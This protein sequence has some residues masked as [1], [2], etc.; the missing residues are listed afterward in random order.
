MTGAAATEIGGQTTASEYGLMRC[1][2]FATP[3]DIEAHQDT[4]L[5]IV[6]E[7]S[8]A[9]YENDLGKLSRNLERFTECTRYRYGKHAIVFLGDFCQLECIGG[10]VIYN[11][12]Q[13][14]YW[15]QALNSMVELKGTHRYSDCEKMKS[16]MPRV[17]EE[18]LSAEDRKTL[19]SRVID[20]KKIT[21]PDPATT[22]YATYHNKNRCE[23][24]ARVFKNYLEVYHATCT[25]Q[26]IPKTGIVIKANARWA[27]TKVPLSF[28]QRKILFE[29]CSDA[30]CKSG[31]QHCDP[32]L[33]LF[34]NCNVMG[35]TNDD[36]DNGIANGVTAVFKQIHLLDEANLVPIQLYGFWVY[37]VNIQDVKSLEM[38]WQDSRFK[39]RFRVQPKK[40]NFQVRYPVMEFGKMMYLKPTIQF[41]FFPILINHATTGHKL[42]G[43][44]MDELV[45]AEW[46]KVK[47]WAYVVL[48][49]VRTLNGLFLTEEIPED[50]EF[51]PAPKY[52]QMMER[53]RPRILKTPGQVLELLDDEF[54]QLY[55][56]YCT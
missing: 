36:V 19:N 47:N 8:F 33:C 11:H 28:E 13:G 21:M 20:G 44:S 14:I 25:E 50:I 17:R 54:R 27:R 18:G 26:N 3:E 5:N 43:K 29:E 9:T 15:E 32:L 55:P 39:G 40:Q 49:R 42:Q 24:N 2:E 10:D 51:G 38:E 45:I 34:S 52:L 23:I 37:S 16:I 4:R 6:D 31:S 1:T 48:S 35:T 22:R 30:D 12:E 53:L 7:I 56:N 46:S 41:D